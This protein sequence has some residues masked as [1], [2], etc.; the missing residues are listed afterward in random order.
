MRYIG[1]KARQARRIADAML[2]RRGE[3]WAYLEP[4]L[5]AASVATLMAPEFDRV[6]LT[7]RHLDIPHLWRA[8]RDGWVPPTEMDVGQYTRLSHAA[9]SALRAW[10]G[11]AASYNGKWFGGYGP[12]AP[13]AGR[14][15]LAEAQRAALRKAPGLQGATIHWADYR[16]HLPGEGWLVYCDPPYADTMGYYGGGLPPTFDHEEFWATMNTWADL[17]ARVFVSEYTAPEGWTSVLDCDRVATVH[18]SGSV[19]KRREG[20]FTPLEQ[21]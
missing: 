10:A 13:S 4:F 2:A 11:F 12:T 14:D 21:T 1:G 5:G 3:T 19:A 20:L 18:H 7:D 6:K 9:P 17:G 8:I 15:Y 16:Q